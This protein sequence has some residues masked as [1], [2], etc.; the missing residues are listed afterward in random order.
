MPDLL[1]VKEIK[2]PY[3]IKYTT[4]SQ[5]NKIH[6]ANVNMYIKSSLHGRD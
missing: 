6:H 1:K 5:T 4:F 2:K 3:T